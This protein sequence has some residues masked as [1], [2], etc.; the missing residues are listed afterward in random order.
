M[1]NKN[2]SNELEK[3]LINDFEKININNSNDLTLSTDKNFDYSQIIYY[4][5][6]FN[7]DEYMRILSMIYS[8]LKINICSID[9]NKNII[10][11]NKN[12]SVEINKISQEHLKIIETFIPYEYFAFENYSDPNTNINKSLYKLNKKFH[13]TMLYTGGKEDIRALE[14]EKYLE[15]EIEVNLIS[16]GISDKF[17]VCGIEFIPDAENIK[18]IPYYGNPIKHITIG[19]KQSELKKNKLLPKDSPSAFVD[20]IKIK[21]DHDI[22]IKGKIIKECKEINKKK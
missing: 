10:W 8:N 13:T 22:K 17:I 1:E 7:D 9:D 3:S 16:I 2:I 19:I 5:L 12:Q 14:L 21:L 6:I 20:G 18:L 15:K 11:I 4:S